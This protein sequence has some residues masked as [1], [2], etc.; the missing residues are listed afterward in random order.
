[1]EEQTKERIKDKFQ[2]GGKLLVVACPAVSPV[3]SESLRQRLTNPN[4]NAS[5]RKQRQ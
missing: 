2:T 4:D 3:L 5:T 1:M